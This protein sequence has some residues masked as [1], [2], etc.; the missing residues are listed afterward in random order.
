MVS[1]G[2]HAAIGLGFGPRWLAGFVVGRTLVR[3]GGLKSTL[4]AVLDQFVGPF[5]RS[6]EDQPANSRHFFRNERCGGQRRRACCR[7]WAS[8]RVSL[9]AENQA[10]VDSSTA[11]GTAGWRGNTDWN[12]RYQADGLPAVHAGDNFA[13]IG[14]H[15]WGR[16]S[17][18][19][20]DRRCGEDRLGH[21]R[22]E[23][24]PSRG[25]ASRPTAR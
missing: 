15:R 11:G 7:P 16:G 13:F 22:R 19:H 5:N 24:G 9:K 12:G 18:R 1:D 20:G 25:R 23:G 4:H 6:P 21:R 17:E 8:G 3:L 10:V 14:C 2:P